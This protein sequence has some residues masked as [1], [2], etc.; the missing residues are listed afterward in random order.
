M[1]C[2]YIQCYALKRNKN[3]RVGRHRMLEEHKLD[4]TIPIP[5][6]FQLKSLL[7]EEIKKMNI[8]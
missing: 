5:L 3:G 8:P 2:Y 6:Y 7:L 1:Y 4:K